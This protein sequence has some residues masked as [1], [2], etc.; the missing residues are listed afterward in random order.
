[1]VSVIIPVYN[2]ANYLEEAVQSVLPN[3]FVQEIILVEDNSSDNSLEI[4]NALQ[5]KYS[6]K[7]KVFQ[8]PR[9]KNFGA[10]LSRNLGIRKARGIYI[11]FLDGDDVFLTNRFEV[12]VPLLENDRYLDG[13]YEPTEVWF[14][15][16]EYKKSGKLESVRSN[17]GLISVGGDLNPEKLFQNLVVKGAGS[18]HLNGLTLRRKS[19]NNLNFS[20]L[21]LSQDIEFIVKLSLVKRL[22]AGPQNAPVAK[23]RFHGKNRAVDHFRKTIFFRIQ[24]WKNLIKW[25]SNKKDVR[26]AN[27]VILKLRL[28]YDGLRYLRYKPLNIFSI[29]RYGFPLLF[30]PKVIWNFYRIRYTNK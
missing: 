2:C 28:V 1:M 3:R 29:I 22:A 14:F 18:I 21:E 25:S 10:G 12:S 11:S 24:M 26:Y 16:Q 6:E 4:C 13:V 15:D 8:Q 19:I 9:G 30:S 17:Q 20:S 23:Y 7:V 5:N 27:K